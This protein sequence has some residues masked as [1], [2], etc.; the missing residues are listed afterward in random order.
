MMSIIKGFVDALFVTIAGP[1]VFIALLVGVLYEACKQSF[2]WGRITVLQILQGM[3]HG[4][5]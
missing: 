2:L 3:L 4:N 1:F 5:D